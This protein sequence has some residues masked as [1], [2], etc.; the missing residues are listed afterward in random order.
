[1]GRQALL[2]SARS[3]WLPDKTRPSDNR[4]MTTDERQQVPKWIP[5]LEEGSPKDD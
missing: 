5:M 4:L 1:M 3:K 2:E